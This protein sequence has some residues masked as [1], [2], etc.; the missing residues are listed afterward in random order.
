MNAGK[1]LLLKNYL[2]NIQVN[3][4]VAAYT[5]CPEDWQEFDYIPEYNKFYLI[6]EGEGMLKIGDR[7]IYPKPGQ[8]ALMPAGVLQSYSTISENT[9]R[10]HWCHFTATIGDSNLFDIIKLPYTVDVADMNDVARLFTKLTEYYNSNEPTAQL[11]IKSVL[12]EIIAYFIDNSVVEKVHLSSSSSVEL[13]NSIVG[14]IENH[15]SENI[16]IEQLAKLC[17]FH[18]NYF[19][20]FF[21]K[22]MG[23]SPKHYINKI[24]LEKAKSLLSASD[25]NITEIAME[26]GFSDIFYFSKIFKAYTGFSPSQFR[27][28]SRFAK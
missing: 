16:S 12:L 23:S 9:Y 3:L 24:K 13:I 14:Y 20:R 17:H 22:H 19:I 27:N 1:K 6:C 18:P 8:L 4:I 2:S 28:I 21:K 10:K 25:M 7:I 11:K 15:L 5:K 26:T